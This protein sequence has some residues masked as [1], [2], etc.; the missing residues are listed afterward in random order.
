MNNKHAPSA[1]TKYVVYILECE[2]GTLYT[3]ITND[4]A[5]RLV[6]H[7]EG[8]GSK[9]TRAKGAVKVV[10]TEQLMSR[11]LALKREIEIKRLKRPEK[12]ALIHGTPCVE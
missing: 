11:S 4:L 12:L 7:R 5:R 2:D 1:S 10:Y 9:Y 3:G 8:K 6:T